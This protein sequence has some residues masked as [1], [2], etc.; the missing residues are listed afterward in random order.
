MA[1]NSY[2]ERHVFSHHVEKPNGDMEEVTENHEEEWRLTEEG[3]TKEKEIEALLEERL[4]SIFRFLLAGGIG[5][6]LV[7]AAGAALASPAAAHVILGAGFGA[8]LIW[9]AFLCA[10]YESAQ[11]KKERRV[12]PRVAEFA[13]RNHEFMEALARVSKQTA[14]TCDRLI[15]LRHK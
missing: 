12:C 7:F 1:D 8:Y 15:K 3:R 11:R 14:K 4:P 13:A 6:L 2:L 5:G 9:V 10:I